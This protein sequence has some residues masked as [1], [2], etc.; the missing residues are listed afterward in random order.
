[1]SNNPITSVGVDEEQVPT[2]VLDRIST[3]DQVADQLR[4]LIWSGDL[5]PGS[6]LKE[7]PLA[8]S[9]GVS[10]NTIRDAIRDLT[11]DGLLTHELHRGA[12]VR[13]LDPEDVKD[14]FLVRRLLELKAVGQ[15]NVTDSEHE[16]IHAA[17]IGIE[18]AIDAQDWE[19][20]VAADRD[21]HAALVAL[22][23]SPRINRFYE[24]I[25]AESRFVLGILWLRDAAEDVASVVKEVADEHSSIYESVKAGRRAEAQRML[26]EHLTINEAHVLAILQQ[27]NEAT[28][29]DGV[30]E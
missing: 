6:R 17:V 14:L 5:Q 21:F 25:S 8:K 22:L 11:Q 15:R 9:F 10:R 4:R 18:R 26:S 27:R 29:V 16:R 19:T 13:Q 24:Q 28:S 30:A 12:V 20:A 3:V 7:V 1:M 2:F 23:R